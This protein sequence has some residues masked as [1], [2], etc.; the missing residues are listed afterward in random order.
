RPPFKWDEDIEDEILTR[1]VMGEAVLTI[2]GPDRNAFLPSETTF[3]SRVADDKDFA[4][5]YARAKEALAHRYVE[6]IRSIAMAATPEKVG[7][8]R[9]QTDVLK[10]TAARLARRHYGDKVAVGGDE[11]MP[12][13]KTEDA[14]ARMLIESRLAGLAARGSAEG[15]TGGADE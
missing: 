8:A 6:E 15:D 3:Y 13:I 4:E 9:L 14:S 1:I 7:V 5:K 10:W 12:P 2:C 11:D